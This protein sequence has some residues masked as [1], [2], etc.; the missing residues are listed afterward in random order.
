MKYTVVRSE[1]GEHVSDWKTRALAEEGEKLAKLV[2]A[3]LVKA[4][5]IKRPAKYTIQT[6]E[7]K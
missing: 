2:D 3:G 6:Q 4:G 5:W 7:A 1:T